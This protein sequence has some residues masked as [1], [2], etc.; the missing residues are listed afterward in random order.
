MLR[1]ESRRRLP[2]VQ[3]A[4]ME[5]LLFGLLSDFSDIP[6]QMRKLE[7]SLNGDS[8]QVAVIKP[9]DIGDDTELETLAGMALET[10]LTNA[11]A[12]N[13]YIYRMNNHCMAAILALSRKQPE[14]D[15]HAILQDALAEL[16]QKQHIR[17]RA[18]LGKAYESIADVNLSYRQG[19]RLV[20]GEAFAA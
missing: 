7:I 9:L 18:A 13:C 14:R 11:S 10:E 3:V 8:Y 15:G 1:E 17:V 5:R 2:F 12:G 19:G 20:S 4:F 6:S 16:K